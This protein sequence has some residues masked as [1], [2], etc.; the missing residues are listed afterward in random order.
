MRLATRAQSKAAFEVSFLV[1]IRIGMRSLYII[2]V[3]IFVIAMVAV[4]L[5]RCC[6]AKK[7]KAGGTENIRIQW[8]SPQECYSKTV[9]T[10]CMA[11]VR[12]LS[13]FAPVTPEE[14]E[15]LSVAATAIGKR[16]SV[17]IGV[18]SL[19]AMR[20]MEAALMAQRA[21]I[22]AQRHGDKILASY[23]AG[24]SVIEIA[25]Q[26]QLPPVAVLRQILVELGHSA[27][28]VRALLQNPS[29]L[30]GTLPSQADA[31]FAADLGSRVNADRI[32]A[33]ATAFEV[34]LG[35][36][37]RELGVDFTTEN[38]ARQGVTQNTLTPDFLLSQPIIINDR[39][40]HWIDAKNYPMYG[41]R[42][43]AKGLARQAQKYTEAFGPGAF[44]FSGGILCGARIMPA[45]P[46]LLDGSGVV[47]RP[48]P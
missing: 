6:Q 45:A 25:K 43:V 4:T 3:I 48:K 29:R 30:P 40:V 31:I 19:V 20:T 47:D 27:T 38:D 22:R 5:W 8:A 9:I 7:E 34:A 39:P 11:A 41:G 35:A 21:G 28:E 36:R 46:L 10:E 24:E 17:E 44:V 14:R 32:Q 23:Q 1:T 33:A 12:G 37:L 42:L 15:K 2:A 18:D 26:R 13:G 16:H